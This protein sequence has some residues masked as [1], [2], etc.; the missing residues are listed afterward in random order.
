LLVSLCCSEPILD[1]AAKIIDKEAIKKNLA[2]INNN[3]ASII[4]RF[5]GPEKVVIHIPV[6]IL[7]SL[8]ATNKYETVPSSGSFPYK[9][10]KDEVEDAPAHSFTE[11][12]EYH[13]LNTGE[14]RANTPPVYDYKPSAPAAPIS[15]S[16]PITHYEVEH[17][18]VKS[19]DEG[20]YFMLENGVLKEVNYDDVA[21][22]YQSHETPTATP[23]TQVKREYAELVEFVTQTPVHTTHAPATYTLHKSV[24]N[25]K[26]I[27]VYKLLGYKLA[28]SNIGALEV[29]EI[30]SLHKVK[31]VVDLS[32]L[33]LK[34]AESPTAAK[35]AQPLVLVQAPNLNSYGQKTNIQWKVPKATS[36]PVVSPVK[37]NYAPIQTIIHNHEGYQPAA[38]QSTNPPTGYGAGGSKPAV[39]FHYETSSGQQHGGSGHGSSQKVVFSSPSASGGSLY[40]APKPAPQHAPQP[41]QPTA[42]AYHYSNYGQQYNHQPSAPAAPAQYGYSKSGNAPEPGHYSNYAAPEPV[43]SNN[44]QES[45]HYINYA[46]QEPFKTTHFHTAPEQVQTYGQDKTVFPHSQAPSAPLPEIPHPASGGFISNGYYVR[47]PTPTAPVFEQP[48]EQHNQHSHFS[49]QNQPN[50]PNYGYPVLPTE[51]PSFVYQAVAQQNQHQYSHQEQPHYSVQSQEKWSQPVHSTAQTYYSSVGGVGG[52]PEHEISYNFQPSA[53]PGPG[54]Q[55]KV[56]VIVAGKNGQPQLQQQQHPQLEEYETA[57]EDDENGENNYAYF[58]QD[59]SGHSESRL[60]SKQVPNG[61]SG[62]L[63][64]MRR[65]L[66]RSS[67]TKNSRFDDQKDSSVRSSETVVKVEAKP[68]NVTAVLERKMEINSYR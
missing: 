68:P 20:K 58:L 37:I 15:T 8:N 57:D 29:V 21:R 5:F 36:A 2:G 35:S 55:D 48:Q 9:F 28:D 61:H 53:G 26:P 23:A 31:K 6:D 25:V 22:N 63:R 39:H 65:N 46:A 67:H 64:P 24:P 4:H 12:V 60:V 10:V 44:V 50:Q 42:P 43:K 66:T 40:S 62:G 14:K 17:V 19:K 49:P 56:L 41:V 13:G 34:A 1:K 32:S 59:D 16:A 18:S 38:K 45:P 30:N 11:E 52:E 7:K 51:D 27:P 33:K 47:P 3:V 54:E